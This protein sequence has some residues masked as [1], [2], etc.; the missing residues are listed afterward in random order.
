MPQQRNQALRKYI[1]EC[2]AKCFH[3]LPFITKPIRQPETLTA[4]KMI[5]SPLSF[6]RNPSLPPKGVFPCYPAKNSVSPSPPRLPPAAFR[7]LLLMPSNAPSCAKPIA[8]FPR[9]GW[10]QA[11]CPATTK[12]RSQ[13]YPAPPLMWNLARIAWCRASWKSAQAQMA[14][15][16]TLATKCGCLKT[17]T[18]N[19]CFKAVAAW[20]ASSLPPLAQRPWQAQPPHPRSNAATPWLAW[21][22]GIKARATHRLAQ[23]SKRGSILPT[24]PQAK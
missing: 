1:Q 7:L 3:I 13:A 6:Y 15:R 12:P 8:W 22:A 14:S 4:R 21:M 18:A 24:N 16:I 9:N 17:G 2:R 10:A 5:Q 20:M 11:S 23:T 19:F